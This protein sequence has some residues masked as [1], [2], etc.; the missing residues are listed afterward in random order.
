M[1][2]A[3]LVSRYPAVSHTFILREVRALRALGF[4]VASASVNPP[5]RSSADMS[6]EEREEAS[7]TYYIKRHGAVGAL[8]AHAW[9]LLRHPLRYARG[10][11]YALG[12][13]RADL[14]RLAFAFFYF[15][16]A[17]MVARWMAR[18]QRAHLHVHFATAAANIGMVV[19]RM[20]P[21]GL[22][23]TLHGPDE[24]YD[25]GS[26]RLAEKIAIADFV[27]CIGRFARS[28][29]M[30]LSS[31][32]HWHKFE[33][34]PL[35]VDPARY[36]A[37]PASAPSD[38]LRLLCVGRLVPAKGQ[39]ILVEACRLLR[40]SGRRFSLT[41]VGDGP[42]RPALEEAVRRHGLG[43]QVRFTGALNEAQVLAL[44][45]EADAFVL[46]SFAEGIPVVLMEAMAM[47]VPC[48]TTRITGIPELIEAGQDGLLVTPSD[49]AELCAAITR[50]MDEPQL[51]ARLAARGRAKVTSAF[52][53]QTNVR[54][55]G[56][57]FARRIAMA[58][59]GTPRQAA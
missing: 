20:F 31:Q 22:S 44:Y 8:A 53:L 49:A 15:T 25:A 57:I 42:D 34:A 23:L 10:L 14:A 38:T 39:R 1:K 7:A 29:A 17:L 41:L 28:Q 45:R 51:H 6:A 50:L 21:V 16:E 40:E 18:S 43:A 58:P 54:R 33:I 11:R 13:A 48:V 5:D 37:R 3:Y 55:L 9:G 19:R 59:T 2:L 52:D 26:Q 30:K 32:L 4:D 12:L 46:P 35:G 47:G 27:V 24:F 36:S 56:A